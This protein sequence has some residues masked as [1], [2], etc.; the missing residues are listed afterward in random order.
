MSKGAYIRGDYFQ[1][2]LTF[3]IL[4]YFVDLKESRVDKSVFRI[5]HRPKKDVLRL[6]EI[7]IPWMDKLS[8]WACEILNFQLQAGFSE[9]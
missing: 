4:R 9:V 8:H 2:G 1:R 7:R 5:I 6:R 3:G